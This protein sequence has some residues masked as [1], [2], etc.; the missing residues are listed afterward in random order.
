[1]AAANEQIGIARAAYY[2]VLSLG[3]LGGL[4][5]GS[6]LGWFTWP[7]RVWA[8][9]QHR[10]RPYTTPAAAART[11]TSRL[12]ITMPRSPTTGRPRSPRFSR[13]KITYPRRR[14]RNRI[15]AAETSHRLRAGVS[16]VV[17]NPLRRRRR[18]DL[19]VVTWQTAALQNERAD[20]DLMRRRLDASVLLIKALGGGWHV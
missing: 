20:I 12:R 19:Q 3:A 13:W 10:L 15:A 18:Y 14:A 11:P 8:G 5:A 6:L 2:P 1:M 9:G 4:N 16:F 7:S 17:P